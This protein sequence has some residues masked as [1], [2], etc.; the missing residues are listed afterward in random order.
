M[1]P[2]GFSYYCNGSALTHLGCVR[3]PVYLYGTPKFGTKASCILTAY[4]LKPKIKFQDHLLTWIGTLTR[5]GINLNLLQFLKH[6]PASKIKVGA[7]MP[8]SLTADTPQTPVTSAVTAICTVAVGRACTVCPNVGNK[9]S[10]HHSAIP[11]IDQDIPLTPEVKLVAIPSTHEDTRTAT[12]SARHP[13][14]ASRIQYLSTPSIGAE[15]T[16]ASWQFRVLRGSA[17]CLALAV[18]AFAA[19]RLATSPALPDLTPSILRSVSG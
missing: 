5:L 13:S 10:I 9:K 7:R 19:S 14:S 1:S 2:E 8:C 18:T 12:S 16:P 11:T 4:V 3:I 15:R 17:R 6:R